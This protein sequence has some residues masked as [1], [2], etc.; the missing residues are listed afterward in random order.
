MI[1]DAFNEWTRSSCHRIV[2]DAVMDDA[3]FFF[4]HFHIGK[5]KQR[6]STVQHRTPKFFVENIRE[7]AQSRTICH[8]CFY[9]SAVV[10]PSSKIYLKIE[11]LIN[12]S[13]ANVSKSD[14]QRNKP[15]HLRLHGCEQKVMA[16]TDGGNENERRSSR[17]WWS[18]KFQERCAQRCECMANLNKKQAFE[19]CQTYLVRCVLLLLLS[20]FLLSLSLSRCYCFVHHLMCYQLFIW[21]NLH[22][23]KRM[24]MFLCVK[25]QRWNLV[26]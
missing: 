4:F 2:F 19:W 20:F 21:H 5:L 16:K 22:R 18:T 13:C 3:S 1:D 11:C 10:N 23:T 7:I 17:Q 26:R 24:K 9:Y 8:L 25:K 15:K 6:K 14:R 12:S